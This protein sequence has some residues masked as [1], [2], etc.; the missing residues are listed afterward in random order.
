MSYFQFNLIHPFF[1]YSKLYYIAIL[2]FVDAHN[3][4]AFLEKTEVKDG[5]IFHQIVDF[6]NATHIRY[7]LTVNPTIYVSQI[8]K[9][10][11]T[12]TAITIEDGDTHEPIATLR[13]KVDGVT[14]DATE[15]S[16]RRLL[17]LDYQGGI[18]T[19]LNPEILQHISVMRYDTS[20]KKLTFKKGCFSPQWRFFIHTLLHCLSPKKTSFEKFSTTM[21][22]SL[23]CL[24]TNRTFK[25][26]KFIFNC[27]VRNVKSQYKF[28]MYPRFFQTVL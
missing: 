27:M 14:I 12:A 18:I 20:N 26:S 17:H 10:W 6:L 9:F 2:E 5:P 23:I 25:F 8:K 11:Q 1:C 3:Q 13:A 28:L 22:I 16:L 7:A 24:A 4:V 15:S 21:A 19:L